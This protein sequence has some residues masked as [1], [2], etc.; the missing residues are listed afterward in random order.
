MLLEDLVPNDIT[1]AYVEN[2]EFEYLSIMC[3]LV[4]GMRV[5][6]E[7]MAVRSFETCK[8]LATSYVALIDSKP[9]GYRNVRVIS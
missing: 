9:R 1:Q 2:C 8:D 7:L 3:L 5:V 4:D 6:Q